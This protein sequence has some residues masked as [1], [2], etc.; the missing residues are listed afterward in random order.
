MAGRSSFTV[1][2]F[3]GEGSRLRR[4]WSFSYLE[5]A[6]GRDRALLEALAIGT[7][8]PVHIGVGEPVIKGA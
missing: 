3:R 1:K 4:R 6:D 2:V 7:L 5:V 8:C